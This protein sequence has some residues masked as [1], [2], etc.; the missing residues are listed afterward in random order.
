VT[1]GETVEQ[2]V[3]REIKE[4]VGITVENVKYVCS[5]PWPFPDS[6][7]LGFTAEYKSGEITID[8]HEIEE[9]GWFNKNH[10]PELPSKMSISRYLIETHLNRC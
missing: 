9:A 1:I 4:E 2:A 5:Q 3:L 10:L 7:M 6:L 8:R